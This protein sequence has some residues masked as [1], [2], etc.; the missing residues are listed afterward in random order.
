MAM[1][2]AAPMKTTPSSSC[3]WLESVRAPRPAMRKGPTSQFTRMLPMLILL[4]MLPTR[5]GSSLYLT[6]AK[7][8]SNI[9]IMPT[10]VRMLVFPTR[11]F[12]KTAS[13]CGSWPSPMPTA[14]ASRIQKVRK[15]SKPNF[16][17][18]LLLSTAS[19]QHSKSSPYWNLGHRATSAELPRS[20][21]K[22]ANLTASL[23]GR[24]APATQMLTS[25][26]APR[27]CR[28]CPT[29]AVDASSPSCSMLV[30]W[31]PPSHS[32]LGMAGTVRGA[33]R[34]WPGDF[35]LARGPPKA[36]A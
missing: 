33:A 17:A 35:A 26:S 20:T 13:T 6:A 21:S 30:I 1:Q 25:S 23:L 12:S 34:W 29:V 5:P 11:S 19:G 9:A 10:A 7:G 32:Q 8:G 2:R 22:S 27:A 36:A 24:R 16:G 18:G 15:R 28:S 3:L 31:Q 14:A 4:G